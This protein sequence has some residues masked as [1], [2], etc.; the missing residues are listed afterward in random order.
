MSCA[1]ESAA[2][3]QQHAGDGS[4]QLQLA[5]RLRHRLDL[6]RKSNKPVV[7]SRMDPAFSHGDACLLDALAAQVRMQRRQSP[8]SGCW[9][10]T[11]DPPHS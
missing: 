5:E 1:V 3:A 11:D 4:R 2:V 7:L 9:D 6:N 10:Q 8:R